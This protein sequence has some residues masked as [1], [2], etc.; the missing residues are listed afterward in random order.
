MENKINKHIQ[1]QDERVSFDLC[2]A[3]EA[4]LLEGSRALK[5]NVFNYLV[6]KHRLE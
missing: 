1:N 5:C 4:Q 2:G 3:L 6:I